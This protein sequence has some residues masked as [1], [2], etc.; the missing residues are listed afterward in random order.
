ML[1]SKQAGTKTP[2]SKETWPFLTSK[3]IYSF[4]FQLHYLEWGLQSFPLGLLKYVPSLF[5][6]FSRRRNRE[7]NF[8][9]V[10]IQIRLN[11]EVSH[12]RYPS[13]TLPGSGNRNNEDW[14]NLSS[15]PQPPPDFSI[16][17]IDA[18]VSWSPWLKTLFFH[19]SP[20]FFNFY[21]HCE[22]K[23]PVLPPQFKI[24]LTSTWIIPS[25]LC[26]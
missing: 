17:I 12:S 3:I 22:R 20:L 2:R 7:W 21:L 4:K 24:S 9:S 19:D 11:R 18:I 6:I 13:Q 10:S 15:F 1:S 23:I 16:Y 8:N 25:T 5:L 26:C 14:K